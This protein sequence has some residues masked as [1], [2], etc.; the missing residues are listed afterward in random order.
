MG[1]NGLRGVDLCANLNR[2]QA[3]GPGDHSTTS[4]T[5]VSI[6]LLGAAAHQ[7]LRTGDRG[8][9]VK[10]RLVTRFLSNSH[11]VTIESDHG[12]Q[13]PTFLRISKD[14]R[15]CLIADRYQRIGCSKINPHGHS[16][17]RSTIVRGWGGWYRGH[18]ISVARECP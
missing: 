6:D 1:G 3:T 7:S 15:A 10:D 17:F 18:R 14:S 16:G 11:L 9:R 5:R 2:S 8:L 12:R 4:E 13:Q